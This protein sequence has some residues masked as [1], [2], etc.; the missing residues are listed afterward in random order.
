MP[1]EQRQPLQLHGVMH[2][3]STKGIVSLHYYTTGQ[4]LR[5]MT[6]ILVFVTSSHQVHRLY[7]FSRTTP[8]PT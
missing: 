7:T 1:C 5:N 3:T 2:R 6:T 8:C 4:D